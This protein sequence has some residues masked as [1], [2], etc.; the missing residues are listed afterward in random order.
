ML[1]LAILGF[2]SD[3]PLHGYDLKTRVAALAGHVR[4]VADGTLYPT[5]KRLD[6]ANYLTRRTA[7][8]SVAAPR[9]MLEITQEGTNQ[10]RR[11]LRDPKPV[12]ITDDNRWYVLLA[13]LRHLDN[14]REQALVLQ[15]RLAFLS[16]PAVLFMDE[17]GRAQDA[18]D[19]TDPFRL[20]LLSIHRSSNHAE[21]RWLEKTIEELNNR[22]GY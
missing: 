7:P 21:H 16:T 2:L 11:W 18:E 22:A 5:I 14:P 8:G 15:K 17:H 4:P 19:I 20:G 10:L 13:F 12:F 1:K 3:Y 6:E 9:H